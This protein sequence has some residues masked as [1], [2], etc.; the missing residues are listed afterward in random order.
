MRV[1]IDKHVKAFHRAHQQVID[2][3]G[4]AYKLARTPN[5][6]LV[7]AAGWERIHG[8]LIQRERGWGSW[9]HMEFR[10]EQHYTLWMLKWS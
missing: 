6:N 5:F 1:R 9:Q 10:D 2:D 3:C 7:L 4:G 8:V